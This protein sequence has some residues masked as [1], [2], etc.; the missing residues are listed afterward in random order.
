MWVR[1]PPCPQMPLKPITFNEKDL[2][3][4]FKLDTPVARVWRQIRRVLKTTIWFA[5]IF[6]F[7]FYGL[8]APAFWQR[9]SFATNG[10]LLI[11]QRLEL[12]LPA[13]IVNYDPEIIIPKIGVR[14]PVIYD[15][16]LETIIEKL[17]SGVVRY[18]GTADPGQVGNVVIFGHSSDLPW[19]T[20]QYKTIFALLDKLT[21]GDEMILPV[22]PNRYVYK[23]SQLKIVKS[24]DL[25]VLS[26]TPTPILTLVTC[27]PIGT[28]L[29]R[30]VVIANQT[31]GPIGSTQT[32]EP[33]LAEKL[34]TAR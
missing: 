25:T 21:V 19:S 13:P 6:G 2:K 14:A 18:E 28:T 12:P 33:F 15:A 32:T 8:N 20:G 26:R 3:K 5:A 1:L 23:V 10:P 9:A 22:G 11:Q 30:L 29:N 24:S 17:R 34:T 7:F 31:D 27:Y 16:D 4:L